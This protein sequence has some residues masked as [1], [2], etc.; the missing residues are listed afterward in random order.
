MPT[1]PLHKVDQFAF[2]FWAGSPPTQITEKVQ[3]LDRAGTE[4]S[5]FRTLAKRGEIFEC[6]LTSWHSTWLKARD[7]YKQYL[8]LIGQ[9]PVEVRKDGDD[10]LEK[11]GTKYVVLDVKETR[12][13]KNVRLL[14][15]G[16]NY[17]NGVELVTR[18]TMAPVEAS[19]T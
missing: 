9:D 19:T 2:E 15:P 13:Q 12:C 3:K 1:T 6:E 5:T 17:S 16:K 7:A 14:G 11:N 18:W 10:F 4:G 8:G